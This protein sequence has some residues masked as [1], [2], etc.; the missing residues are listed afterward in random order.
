MHGAQGRALTHPHQRQ[1]KD[2]FGRAARLLRRA[3][4]MSCAKRDPPAAFLKGSRVFPP[5]PARLG[6]SPSD[7]RR[8][9]KR[10]ARP[11]GGPKK[12]PK[13]A[14]RAIRTPDDWNVAPAA[15]PTH[16]E[17]ILRC[18]NFAPP[19]PGA[20]REVCAQS[21]GGARAVCRRCARGLRELREVC[22]RCVTGAWPV[23]AGSACPPHRA[24]KTTGPQREGALKRK[25]PAGGR[26]LSRRMRRSGGRPQQRR[27]PRSL[28]AGWRPSRWP[29]AAAENRAAASSGDQTSTSGGRR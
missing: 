23:R 6:G 21:V 12:A 4:T 5:A 7:A 11:P 26:A 1:Y 13:A 27:R 22:G 28:T 14:L 2:L 9:H 3:V 19:P 20:P 10:D 18:G 15:P 8:P 29:S 24:F 17:K 16:D 25:E